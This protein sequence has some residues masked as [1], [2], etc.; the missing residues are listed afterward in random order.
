VLSLFGC[1]RTDA[2]ATHYRLVYRYSADQGATFTSPTPFLGFTWPLYRLN[3]MGIGEWYVAS[4]DGNGWYPIALPAGPNPWLPEDLLLDWPSY[5][6][7]DG[8]YSVVLE[9]GNAIT[10][11]SQSDPVAITVDN[12]VPTASFVVESSV[13]SSGPWTPIDAICPVVRRGSTPHTMYFRVTFTGSA[14]HLRSLN[15]TAAGCGQGNFSPLSDSGGSFVG[16]VYWHW[17][18]SPAD[19][20][21]TLQVIYQLPSSA[22]QGTYSFGGVVSTRSFSP[23]GFDG[24]QLV[25]PPWQ[26]DPDH[27]PI[28]PSV[29][30][31]VF[32]AD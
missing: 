2:A 17:H 20:S 6:M 1:N 15:L 14:L 18:D 22:A 26:Y 11:S 16:N 7:A 23:S 25:V 10:A 8:L 21:Q 13:S 4:P 28:Y 12:S 9:L 31:S 32:D 24:G 27:A 3:G 5:A 30:F 19:N 29:A